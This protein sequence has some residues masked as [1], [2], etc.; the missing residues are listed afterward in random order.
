MPC[1]LIASLS[2]GQSVTALTEFLLRDRDEGADISEKSDVDFRTVK[3]V[4]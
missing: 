4:E 3:Y 2:A 1:E